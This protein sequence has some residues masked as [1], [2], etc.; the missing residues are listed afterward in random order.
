MK[1]SHIRRFFGRGATRAIF[2]LSALSL[3]VISC[4]R[5]FDAEGNCFEVL[6]RQTLNIPGE[7]LYASRVNSVSLYIFDLDGNLVDAMSGTGPL[8]SLDIEP[9][10]YDL[11]AWGGLEGNRTFSLAGNGTAITKDDLVCR[12][13]REHE[14]GGQAVSRKELDDLFHGSGRYEFS[15]KN[16]VNVIDLAKDNNTVH[17]ILHPR[18][19]GGKLF[20]EDFTFSITDNNGLMNYDNVLLSDETIAYGDWNRVG[21]RKSKAATKPE[22]IEAGAVAADIDI[23]RLVKDGHS[24]ATLTVTATGENATVISL[25]LISTLLMVKDSDGGF[26]MSDQEYLDRQDDYTIE[27]FLDDDLTWNRGLG[28]YINSWHVIFI[29]KDL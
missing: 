27:F 4:E 22:D 5:I 2:C 23:S 6:F 20:Q 12:L 8:M 3:P 10:T 13:V 19:N 26:G 24:A 16:R 29:D 14:A 17:V 18:N 1:L 28:I 9:G 15:M 7:D 21:T 11:V 25:P